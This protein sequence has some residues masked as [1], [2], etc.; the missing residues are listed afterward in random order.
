[1]P[2]GQRVLRGPG[3][4]FTVLISGPG[5]F[6]V[7]AAAFA[8]SRLFAAASKA[9]VLRC[10]SSTSGSVCRAAVTPVAAAICRFA[11]ANQLQ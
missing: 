2:C 5:G 10:S 6:A 7:T 4:L 1:M 8:R 9:A 3:V 11:G